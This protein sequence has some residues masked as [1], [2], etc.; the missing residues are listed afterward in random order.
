M[1]QPSG[2]SPAA[3]E[4]FEYSQPTR[5]VFGTGQ[6]S[7][8]PKLVDEWAGPVPRVLLVT[9]RSNLR[10]TGV[11]DAVC[12][13][14]SPH[15]ITIFDQVPTNPSPEIAQQAIDACRS[16]NCNIVVAIG[17]R[18]PHRHRQDNRPACSR[19]LRHDVLPAPTQHH[20]LRGLP[21]IAVPTT[22]GSSS[23]VTPFAVTWDKEAAVRYP[24]AHPNLYPKVA[25]V[26]PDL[27]VTMPPSLAAATG[28]DAFTSAFE[29]YWSSHA[30]PV[31]DVLALECISLYRENLES[32]CLQ[33]NADARAKCALASSSVRHGLQQCPHHRPSRLWHTPQPL[34]RHRTRG[35]R[36]HHLACFP[37]LECTNLRAKAGALAE[38][39][40]VRI[41]ARSFRYLDWHDAALQHQHPLGRPRR[42][43]RRPATHLRPCLERATD[44]VQPPSHDRRPRRLPLGG[45]PLD[46]EDPSR[47]LSSW[48]TSPPVTSKG[49]RNLFRLTCVS[50]L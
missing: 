3:R 38:G 26:D 31:S 28:M 24:I 11:L 35:S 42:G 16:N 43:P 13:S 32:S 8:L 4:A 50:S 20:R 18:K 40:A 2:P 33:G 5:F 27:V 6:L 36:R 47:T 49:I 44:A 25:I 19:L 9:G 12:H 41:A 22:S 30:Q 14:L 29:A 17:G 48:V 39:H 15:H 1:S 46:S 23:E 45:H 7:Q 34:L 37:P 10:A 21:C